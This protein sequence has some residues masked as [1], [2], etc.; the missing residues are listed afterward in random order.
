M[1]CKYAMHETNGAADLY[2]DLLKQILTRSIVPER[3]RA[4]TDVGGPTKGL[5]KALLPVV[6]RL[7]ARKNLEIVRRYQ[8]DWEKRKQGSEWPP[9]AETMVGLKRLDNVQACIADVLQDGVPGDFIEAGT[10]RG[11]CSI[12]MRA[13]LA[14][15]GDSTRTV[16][17]ADS[18]EGLPKPDAQKYPHDA[19]DVHWTNN[20]YLG[21]SLDTVKANFKRY[22]FLDDRVRFLKGWFKDTLPTVPTSLSQSSGSM[23]ICTSQ[24]SRR[25]MLFIPSSH[26]AGISLSTI[27][28]Y[29]AAALRLT[30]TVRLTGPKKK[31]ELST[32]VV[33]IGGGPLARLVQETIAFGRLRRPE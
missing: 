6:G 12:F 3:Y 2:L 17:V 25:S 13:A 31:F 30:I 33:S 32:G 20:E 4:L 27:T 7:L 14:A 15:F 10:W 19:G 1:L 22:G 11:G 18:F 26:P 28:V 24:P 8:V 5:H 9:D 21:V 29:R 23:V 16:W